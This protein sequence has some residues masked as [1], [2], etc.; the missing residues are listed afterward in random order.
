MLNEPRNDLASAVREL[1]TTTAS[2][3]IIFCRFAP[4]R[5]SFLSLRS[6]P[7]NGMDLYQFVVLLL[8]AAR[9]ASRPR[10]RY[11]LSLRSKPPNGMDLYQFVVLLLQ[12]ARRATG[13]AALFVSVS[14]CSK[15]NT[16]QAVTSCSL[17][18]SANVL[19]DSASRFNNGA[20]SHS[21]PCCR[22]NS[23]MRSYTFFRPT[24]SA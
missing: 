23:C 10:R 4:N 9:R 18:K 7:P 8:Q 20:G 22:W 16:T 11:S 6:K 15:T 1:V 12:A 17:L 3:V 2:F 13:L 14:L 21:S 24:V 19:P 5:S